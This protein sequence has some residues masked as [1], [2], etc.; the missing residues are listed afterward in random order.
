MPGAMEALFWF[1]EHWGDLFQTVGIVAGLLF[2]AFTIRKDG[3]SRKISNQIALKQEHRIIWS[4]LYSRPELTR[5]LEAR[6]DAEINSVTE[7]EKLFVRLLVVHLDTAYRAGKAGMFMSPEEF[8]GDVKEF[9]S[10]PIPR[11]V[12]EQLKPQQDAAFVA[13]VENCRNT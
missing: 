2:T 11:I 7:S 1:E 12:W 6:V 13:F 9:F 10:L 8:R 4:E 5:I 3:E